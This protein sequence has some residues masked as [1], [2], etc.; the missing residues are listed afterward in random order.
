[1]K[2]NLILILNFLFVSSCTFTSEVREPKVV[3]ESVAFLYESDEE[4]QMRLFLSEKYKIGNSGFGLSWSNESKL[5]PEIKSKLI[6]RIQNIAPDLSAEECGSLLYGMDHIRLK[7]DR[8]HEYLFEFSV[9]QNCTRTF[10]K[11]TIFFRLNELID[12]VTDKVVKQY[13][14]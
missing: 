1:M 2:T 6:Q 10:Y 7:K 12:V 8:D 3:P 14:C 9:S 11:G 5:K 4:I 13:P